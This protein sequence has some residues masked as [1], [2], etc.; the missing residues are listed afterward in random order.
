MA[1]WILAIL[2]D[3]L[4]WVCRSIWHEIPVIGGRAQGYTRPR[5]PSLASGTR[6]RSFAEIVTGTHQRTQSHDATIAELRKR[7]HERKQSHNALDESV[8]DE[9]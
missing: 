5:A 1:P 4:L 6:R 2:Y 9:E 8:E 3:F 7:D